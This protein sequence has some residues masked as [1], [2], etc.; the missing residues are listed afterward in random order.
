MF[1]GTEAFLK[2]E[3]ETTPSIRSAAP[4]GKQAAN[5]SPTCQ[6]W[7]LET[8]GPGAGGFLTDPD[9]KAKRGRRG[10]VVTRYWCSCRE[11]QVPGSEKK[12]PRKGCFS[13]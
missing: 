7:P 4:E 2:S 10:E 12:P 9:T 8:A 13:W 1:S 3:G 11:G 5:L 6:S